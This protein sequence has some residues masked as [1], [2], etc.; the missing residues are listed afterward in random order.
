MAAWNHSFLQR[1]IDSLTHIV[2]MSLAAHPN[3]GLREI[4]AQ[5]P[6]RVSQ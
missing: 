3:L 4:S 5:P 6:K 1:L 2:Q